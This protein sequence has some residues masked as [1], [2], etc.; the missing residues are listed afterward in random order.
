MNHSKKS[1]PS[2]ASLLALAFIVVLTVFGQANAQDG[3]G[4]LT[5]ERL[6]NAR[7]EPQNWA[8]YFG[9][10]D[11]W[12]YSSLDQIRADNVKNLVPVWAFQTGKV[13]GG[14]NATPLVVDGIMYLIASENRVFALNAETGQRLWTYNY[15]VPRDFFSPYGKFNRGVAVGYGLVFFGTMDDHVVALTAHTGKEVWNVEVED[16]KKCGCNING[17]PFLVKDKLIV[18][19][20]R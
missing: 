15:E 8:T 2:R 7:K 5:G 17:A 19:G 18:G 1:R 11:A 3:N 12:R 14:L 4:D 9:A 16:V 6:V 10:Y 20:T 13:E